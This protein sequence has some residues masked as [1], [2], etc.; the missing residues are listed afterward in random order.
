MTDYVAAWLALGRALVPVT[1]GSRVPAMRDWVASPIRTAEDAARWAGH[2][3][4]W[5][6]GPGDLVIDVDPRNGG[7]DG[8]RRLN[9]LAG[10]ALFR[11]FPTVRT[12]RGGFHLYVRIPETLRP[13]KSLPGWKGVDWLSAGAYV[14]MPGQRSEYGEYIPVPGS[15]DVAVAA[16]PA[17]AWLLGIFAA[18]APTPATERRGDVLTRSQLSGCLAQLPVGEF[19][20]HGDWLEIM[21]ACHDATAGEGREEFF[22]WSP[23]DPQ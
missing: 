8:L 22:A 13:R 18:D 16:P 7:A 14:M 15:L 9:A 5:A 23:A 1:P 12:P 4:G 17:P 2:S 19:R 10:G 11:Q 3:W 21:Q 6:L 20:E